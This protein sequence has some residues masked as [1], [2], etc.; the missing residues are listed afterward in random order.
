M[1]GQFFLYI[2]PGTGSM[3]FSI[4]I[5]I[6][7]VA[8]YFLRTLFVKIK[9]II[10][11]GKQ[12][13]LDMGKLPI[14]IFS[15]HKRYW[16]T[17]EPICDEL[18]RRGVEAYFWTA[19]PDDPA[20]SKGYEHIKCEFIGE[21]NKAFSRLN[22]LN[23]DIVLATTPS[24]DVFQWKRSK[25]VRWYIHIP[26]SP[27]N[28]NMYR[29]FGIDY[30][31]AMLLSGKH[32][33]EQT[34][35]LEQLRKLPAKEIE[36]V[37][38]PYWDELYK[39]IQTSGSAKHDRLTVLLAPSWGPSSILNVYGEKFIDELI[40][41]GYDIV[42]RPHPQSFTA[43]KET[44]DR[45]MAKYPDGEKVEW[46]RD[47]DNFDILSRADI[48]ISDFSGVLFDFSLLFNKPI[49][50]ANADIN[51]DPF[52]AWWIDETPWTL[53]ILPKLGMPITSES[54]GNL[55]SMIDE[56]INDPKYAKNR[57]EVRKDAWQHPGQSAS[58]IADYL[59]RKLEELDQPEQIPDKPEKKEKAS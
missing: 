56:C 49:M 59:V 7:G 25:N 23:A 13:K 46:N 29:M 55:K 15:D 28:V 20:L 48:L 36:L 44:M 4:L 19:S 43:D 16:N 47:N 24:L 6:I 5:G 35:Q 26:H 32:Q 37:G 42:I 45:L 21:G 58:L 50:Y 41:T 54:M 57:D 27:G 22:L 11:G 34:R 12:A 14:V 31:D 40:K 33:E 9:F 18:E 3:L 53:R 30:F 8:V 1:A 39:R 17:F 2:D 10:S 51:M 38:L 52:D